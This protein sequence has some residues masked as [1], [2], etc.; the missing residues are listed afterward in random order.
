MPVVR[1]PMGYAQEKPKLMRHISQCSVCM[2]PGTVQAFHSQ[3]TN[4]PSCPPNNQFGSWVPLWDG[5][6]F[7]MHA[8]GAAGVG[9]QLDSPGSCL[10]FHSHT[11][12]VECD[13]NRYCH[14]WPDY[15][16]YWLYAIDAH[17]PNST[18]KRDQ[19]AARVG[20]CQVCA[21]QPANA[22][23]CGAGNFVSF[24]DKNF[25]IHINLFNKVHK[26]ENFGKKTK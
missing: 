6:S 17:F 11:P 5:Y 9:Q 14:Y 26:M 10:R 2:A 22:F 8:I 15:M 21:F 4:V 24:F 25:T 7:L 19:V 3:S 18:V 20:R 12:Y 1:K 23:V 13:S 16:M